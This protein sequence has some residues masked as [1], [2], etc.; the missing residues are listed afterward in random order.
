MPDVSSI[1]RCQAPAD[2][3]RTFV[4]AAINDFHVSCRAKQTV[5]RRLAAQVMV[6]LVLRLSKHRMKRVPFVLQGR[7]QRCLV[8]C[9]DKVCTP[10][11]ACLLQQRLDTPVLATESLR[12]PWQTG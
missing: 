10:L 11:R 6:H 3:A 4:D 7:M 1:D 8:R 5:K 2:G 12:T 9:Q